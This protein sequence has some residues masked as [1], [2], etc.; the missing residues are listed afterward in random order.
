MLEIYA[1]MDFFY[2]YRKA[3]GIFASHQKEASVV[4][5]KNQIDWFGEHLE[6]SHGTPGLRLLNQA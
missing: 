2:F 4:A 6:R 3:L 1:K 5:S